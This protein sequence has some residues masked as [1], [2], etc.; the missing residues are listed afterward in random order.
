MSPRSAQWISVRCIFE[1]A[2]ADLR[3]G[4]PRTYEERITL[5]H[6][7]DFDTAIALAEMEESME[8]IGA[9]CSVSPGVPLMGDDPGHGAEVYS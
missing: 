2:P 9:E 5:W 8:I 7:V 1:V 4:D 3:P 6:A